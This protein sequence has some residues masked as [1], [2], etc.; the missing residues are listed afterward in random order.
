MKIVENS[1]GVIPCLLCNNELPGTIFIKA[2]FN[3]VQCPSCGLVYVGNPPT[4]AELQELYSFKSGYHTLFGVNNSQAE[5]NQ[6]K[7][8]NRHFGFLGKYKTAGRLLDI[9]CSAGFFLKTARDNGWETCGIELSED[10]SRIARERYKLEVSTG[11]IEEVSLEPNSFD[12]VTMWDLI[13]HTVNPVNTMLAANSVLKP[14]GLVLLSTPNIDGLFPKLSYK[15]SKIINYWP[16]PEP[17]HH[18]FQ[19]SKKTLTRLLTE[20]GFIPLEIADRRYSIP[21]TFG[22]LKSVIRSPKRLLY[23]AVFSPVMLLG[24]VINAGD[25][26]LVVAKK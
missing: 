17:P 2:G 7:L 26:M 8:A 12:V 22:N 3:I 9:G 4:E 5:Q 24:P 1:Q 13:E 21:Y 20:T 16:H 23:A 10:T 25:E 14:G 19:F 6:L 11:T 15:V 18:L